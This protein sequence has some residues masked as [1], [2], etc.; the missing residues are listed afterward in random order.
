MK[1]G[2]IGAGSIGSLFGGYLASI[3]TDENPLEI[4]FF[5]RENHR[6]A[7][8]KNGL[9]LLA[10]AN[11]LLLTNIR[12]YKSAEEYIEESIKHYKQ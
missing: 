11:N 3:H 6:D 7:I 4:V 10:P 9:E 1:I 12:A 2:F 5:C 8:N